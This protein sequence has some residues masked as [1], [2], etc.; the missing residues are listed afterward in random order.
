MENILHHT[1]EYGDWRGSLY[2]LCRGLGL[3]C[4]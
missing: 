2:G 4:N 3:E 1:K